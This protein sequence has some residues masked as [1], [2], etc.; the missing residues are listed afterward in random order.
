MGSTQLNNEMNL[1]YP[2]G[3]KIMSE[4][5][6]RKHKF[7]EEAPGF[8]INDPER[9]IVLS[10]SWRQANPFVAMLAGTAD[11]ARNMEA[12]IRKPMNKFGYHLEEFMT[13]QIG[14]KTADGYRYT[15]SVQDVGMV[16]ESL[17]VKSG[18]N[19]Y[20]IHSYFR[21]ELREESLKLLDQIFAD[22]TWEE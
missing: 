20:Y 13:R 2:D 9:H 3:F 10:V 19:F 17:S 11:I 1:Q 22:V 8:C 5:E 4:E 6:L 18:S 14:G 12:K 15:Y 21:E 16:G 7:Y